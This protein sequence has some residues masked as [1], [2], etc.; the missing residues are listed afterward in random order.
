MG[1]G[2]EVYIIKGIAWRLG[3]ED[4][5]YTLTYQLG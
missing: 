1:E 4:S 5:K 2:G 3:N